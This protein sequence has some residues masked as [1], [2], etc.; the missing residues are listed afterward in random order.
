MY[1]RRLDTSVSEGRADYSTVLPVYLRVVKEPYPT[2]CVHTTRPHRNNNGKKGK[3]SELQLT[4][5]EIRT[6]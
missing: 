1:E 2:V 5:T 3:I 6:E 4:L